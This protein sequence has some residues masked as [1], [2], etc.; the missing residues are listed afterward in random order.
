[1]KF[2]PA[3][4]FQH[5]TGSRGAS[6]R[7][8]VLIALKF[9]ASA[10]LMW[11]IQRHLD[12]DQLSREIRNASAAPLIAAVALCAASLWLN[13]MRWQ[14][15][16][17]LGG[18]T[19]PYL[20][21]VG[22]AFVGYFFGQAM[23]ATVGDGV[24]AWLV[25]RDGVP[26][27]SAIRSVLVDRSIGF[28]FLILFAAAGFPWLLDKLG[29][30]GWIWPIE[31]GIAVLC[32]AGVTVLWALRRSVWLGGF[33]IGRHMV[34]LATDLWEVL[35]H[36]GALVAVGLI[37]IV[38]QVL[39]CA[40]LWLAAR[41]VGADIPF[42]Q[43]LIVMPGVF[44]LMWLPISIAGWGVREGGIVLG[45]GIFGVPATTALLVSVLFGLVTLFVGLIGGVI[46]LT[47]S[48]RADWQDDLA[49]EP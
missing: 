26:P 36:P 22:H 17:R 41:S 13:A 10:L 35:L 31:G 20:R 49:V 32:M 45:L 11:L 4:P 47:R 2:S 48:Q 14:I 5:K 39:G 24:R 28:G 1:L 23:P 34:D 7:G 33:R 25:Y 46:W 40:I 42:A 43:T 16:L 18:N 37:S 21:L 12:F 9:L 8:R 6:A 3:T 30:E 19:A 29:H 15:V 44:V 27:A 38:V